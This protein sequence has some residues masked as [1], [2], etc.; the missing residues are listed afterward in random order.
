MDTSYDP[1]TQQPT[2]PPASHFKFQRG[3]ATFVAVI[4]VILCLVLFSLGY[5]FLVYQKDLS[6]T[7]DVDASVSTPAED[8]I[9]YK[10]SEYGFKMI[11]KKDWNVNEFG[12]KVEFKTLNNGQV[13]FEAFNDTEFASITEIN[14]RF[15]D[16]FESG[17]REG[18]N[19]SETAQQFD[20]VLHEQNGLK[21]CAAEGEILGFKQKY[22]V[23]YNPYNSNVYTLFY[24][25]SD[26]ASE[27]ELVEAMSSFVLTRE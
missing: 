6:N 9:E 12:T 2:V 19:D 11:V 5:Y 3:R 14:E 7:A 1:S 25:S 22:N 8:E 20:F 24:T 18:I 13:T 21:G 26:P 15:C 17:F 4:T 10:N 23:Y 16:S 27:E